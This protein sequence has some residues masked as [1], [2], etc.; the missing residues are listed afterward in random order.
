MIIQGLDSNESHVSIPAEMFCEATI[1]TRAV[2]GTEQL[3]QIKG[4]PNIWIQCRD[5][6]PLKDFCRTLGRPLRYHEPPL[7]AGYR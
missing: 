3:I 1:I 4:G 7:P 5:V 2:V 6:A